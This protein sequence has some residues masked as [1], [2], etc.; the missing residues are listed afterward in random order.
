[1]GN[2]LQ[3]EG[4]KYVYFSGMENLLENPGD[5]ILIGIVVSEKRKIGAKCVNPIFGS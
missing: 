3:N 4:V 1:M 2:F 5:P